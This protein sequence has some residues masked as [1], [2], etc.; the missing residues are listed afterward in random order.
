MRIRRAFDLQ[1]Q[2]VGES[3][4]LLSPREGVIYRG[5]ALKNSVLNLLLTELGC[6][7]DIDQAVRR[8]VELDGGAPESAR[9]RVNQL[10][11]SRLLVSDED[12]TQ[13][14]VFAGAESW[15]HY[16]WA[17]A[18]AYHAAADAV[19]RVDYTTQDGQRHDVA[20]MR[21]YVAES[22]AP[23]VYMPSASEEV[24]PL[25]PPRTELGAY[26]A[27]L[28]A[29]GSPSARAGRALSGEEL[30]TLLWYGFGR[31]GTKKLPV[32]GEH[33]LK[34]S[35][36]GGSRHPTEAYLVVLNSP[37]VPLGIHHYS[38]RDHA[39]EFIT[40]DVERAWVDRN[41]I[42]KPEWTAC[43]PTAV[44]ILTSR[45]ELNMYRY[46]ENYSYRPVHH[47]VGHLVETTSLVARAIGCRTFSGYS[48]DERAV[49]SKLG[50]ARLLN[51]AMAF[52]LLS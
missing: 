41:V 10:I 16:G 3:T 11:E 6:W 26:T 24:F 52:I 20:A 35:P 43:A 39:L 13:R 12:S 31:T 47:D 15:G 33:L 32:T 34:T 30:S 18:F 23:P 29:D 28:L 14:D 27:E 2:V 44:L 38:V 25:G 21:K 51:P 49:A 17:E 4:L 8:L 48:V 46:R 9:A 22:P 19:R 1:V 36:S 45:V 42:G 5:R 7:T 40:G 50:N 37:D